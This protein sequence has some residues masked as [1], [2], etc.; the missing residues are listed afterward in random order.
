MNGVKVEKIDQPKHRSMNSQACREI[1]LGGGVRIGDRK[2]RTDSHH[3]TKKG[4]VQT[5]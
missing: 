2:R 1:R 5:A 3:E 4:M